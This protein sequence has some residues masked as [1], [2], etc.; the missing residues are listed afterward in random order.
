[1]QTKISEAGFTTKPGLQAPVLHKKTTTK[2]IAKHSTN[3]KISIKVQKDNSEQLQ[4]I[5][6]YLPENKIRTNKVANS[7]ARVLGCVFLPSKNE[8]KFQHEHRGTLSASVFRQV[9]E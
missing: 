7:A 8:M 1:M 2:N 5:A 6:D 9:T 4:I 3:N